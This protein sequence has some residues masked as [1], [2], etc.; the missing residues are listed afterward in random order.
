MKRSNYEFLLKRHFQRAV[1]ISFFNTNDE[2]FKT[3]LYS[4]N[5][6]KRINFLKMSVEYINSKEKKFVFAIKSLHV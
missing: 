5:E 6:K 4:L 3:I 1:R 2:S